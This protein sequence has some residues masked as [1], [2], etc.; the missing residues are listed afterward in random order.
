MNNESKDNIK[1]CYQC[2]KLYDIEEF[3]IDNPRIFLNS[4]DDKEFLIDLCSID[5]M[6]KV[7]G[8]T[9]NGK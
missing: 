5:C 2:L 7:V 1:I 6:E 8:E 3:D 4:V 9:L